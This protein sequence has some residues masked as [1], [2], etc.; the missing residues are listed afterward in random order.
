MRRVAH[1][2]AS[3][4]GSSSLASPAPVTYA[5]RG[6]TRF[7]VDVSP[8]PP[9]PG[10]FRRRSLSLRRTTH[11]AGSVLSSG[12]AM[13]PSGTS[14]SARLTD[15]ATTS[16]MSRRL[17]LSSSPSCS[18]ASMLNRALSSS[19]SPRVIMLYAESRSSTPP[20][21]IAL[22]GGAKAMLRRCVCA[23]PEELAAPPEVAW[24][25]SA[26]PLGGASPT[27]APSRCASLRGVSSL[28]G[29]LGFLGPDSRASIH[30]AIWR[31]C[32]GDT[33]SKCP[34]RPRQ[35]MPICFANSHSTP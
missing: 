8:P 11:A 3:C 22:G 25:R 12:S 9:P 4:S 20:G 30:E 26:S 34:G 32:A 24:R 2:S 6:A 29:C 31:A 1:A 13:S 5:T 7:C 14:A 19:L 18:F 33:A 15:C 28:L 35:F 23:T 16:G 27:S 10:R 17:A 21:G